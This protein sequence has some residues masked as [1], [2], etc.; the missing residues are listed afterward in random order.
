MSPFVSEGK[1]EHVAGAVA[2]RC[3]YKSKK[4]YDTEQ[5]HTDEN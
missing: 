3:I 4:H 2:D 1:S 5:E